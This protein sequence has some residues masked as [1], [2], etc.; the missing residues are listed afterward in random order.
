VGNTFTRSLTV[1]VVGGGSVTRTPDLPGYTDGSNVQLEAIPLTG[2]AF[3]AWSGDLTGNTNPANLLMDADKN[4]TSTFLDIAP[5]TV[6]VTSPNGGE[7]VT[8]GTSA[9][10]SWTASDN[11]AVT[12]V[13]LELSRTGSGGPYEPLATGIANSGSFNWNVTGPV[14]S[15]ALLRATARDAATN[16]TPDVSDAEFSIADPTGVDDGPVTTFALS[17]VLPNPARGAARFHIALPHEANV[18]LAVH[19]VQGRELFVLADG[20]YPAGRH[21]LDWPGRSGARLDPGLYFVRFTAVGRTMVRRF[22]V[23]R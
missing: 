8:V 11:A 4:V 1:T 12:G 5:P 6:A 18:R 16:S 17:P 2:W 7:V 23:V 22:V 15:N 13:D 3:S 14:S 9:T 20:S 19:D 21:S 10:L